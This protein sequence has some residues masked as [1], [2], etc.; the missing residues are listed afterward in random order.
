MCDPHNKK[1]TIATPNLERGREAHFL[2]ER[3]RGFWLARE[4]AGGGGA[5]S[6][7]EEVVCVLACQPMALCV[8]RVKREELQAHH[9][10]LE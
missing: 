10:S 7:L 3:K 5:S 6:S 8:S 9:E 2:C 1:I 4:H